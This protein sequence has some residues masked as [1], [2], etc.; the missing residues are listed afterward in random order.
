MEDFLVP[1]L[2]AMKFQKCTC[3]LRN[4][5]VFNTIFAR[6]WYVL[7]CVGKGETNL[8]QTHMFVKRLY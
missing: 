7:V 5:Y 6:R 1:L 3:Y 2:G 8:P 4:V